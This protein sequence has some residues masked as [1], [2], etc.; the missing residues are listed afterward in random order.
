MRH[1]TP[2]AP[3]LGVVSSTLGICASTPS[4]IRASDYLS[5]LN[6][7]LRFLSLELWN[8]AQALVER[9]EIGRIGRGFH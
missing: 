2:M 3:L 4:T 1:P 6:A 7:T 8:L 9:L 5:S